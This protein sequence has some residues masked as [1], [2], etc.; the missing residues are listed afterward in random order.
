MS[1]GWLLKGE[2]DMTLGRDIWTA[3]GLNLKFSNPVIEAY[4]GSFKGS[5]SPMVDMGPNE[6]KISNYNWRIIYEYLSRINKQIGTS[7]HLY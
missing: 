6:L 2:N 1:C 5:V 7:T 3:L 4:D